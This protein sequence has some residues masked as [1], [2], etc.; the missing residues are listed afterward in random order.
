MKKKFKMVILL[1]G[2]LLLSGCV[3]QQPNVG[4]SNQ[5]QYHQAQNQA[6]LNTLQYQQTTSQQNINN[7][8]QRANQSQI[9]M[10]TNTNWAMQQHQAGVQQ[11][12]MTQQRNTFNSPM[13]GRTY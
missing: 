7:M 8:A 6:Q 3:T 9:N 10:Q 2:V 1:S 4:Q 5:L 12:Q 11:M 13:Y